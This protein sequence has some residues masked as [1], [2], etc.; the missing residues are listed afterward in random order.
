MSLQGTSGD[1]T[2]FVE[3]QEQAEEGEGAGEEEGEEAGDGLGGEEEREEERGEEEE[4][5]VA[6][7]EENPYP[8]TEKCRGAAGDAEKLTD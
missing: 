1:N 3:E 2:G 5:A 4:E 8:E 6:A 7:D